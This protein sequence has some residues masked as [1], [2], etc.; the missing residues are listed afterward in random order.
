MN[1]QNALVIY[2]DVVA[3]KRKQEQQ[4]IDLFNVSS[5]SN[6]ENQLAR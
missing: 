4:Q 1:Q 2:L 3:E 5:S 6:N